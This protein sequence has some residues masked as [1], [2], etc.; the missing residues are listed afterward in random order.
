[1]KDKS[2]AIWLIVTFGLSGMVVIALAWFW[3]TLQP[4]R[5]T[6]TIAGFFGVAIASIRTFTLKK[7][8]ENNQVK[9]EVENNS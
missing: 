9:V 1:M 6:A 2:L 3:P 5:T 7:S 8:I 4:E